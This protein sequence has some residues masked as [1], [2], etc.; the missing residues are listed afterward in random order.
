VITLD[1]SGLLAIMDTKD[2]HHAACLSI[3]DTEDGPFLMSP[4][5]L[6]EMAWLLETR[7]RREVEQR[8]LANIGRGALVLSWEFRD[9]IRIQDLIGRY[10]DLPLGLADAAVVACAE[11]HGGRVLTTDWRHFSVVARG[12]KSIRVLPEEQG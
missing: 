12:E 8:F 11:R 10:H 2:R 3:F 1:T 5:I 6:T 7:F 4:A 9:I